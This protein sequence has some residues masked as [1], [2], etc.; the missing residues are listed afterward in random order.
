MKSGGFLLGL[1]GGG[2]CDHKQVGLGWVVPITLLPGSCPYPPPGAQTSHGQG[3]P[4]L[5]VPREGPSQLHEQ[6]DSV[7]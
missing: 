7:R 6:V 4:H 1:G 5:P 2:F 3:V